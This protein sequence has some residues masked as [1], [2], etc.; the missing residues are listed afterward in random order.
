MKALI[1]VLALVIT[2]VVFSQDRTL[3][4]NSLNF[5]MGRTLYDGSSVSSGEEKG[6]NRFLALGSYDGFVHER[7]SI[8]V[9]GGYTVS[10]LKR[11][12]VYY[13]ENSWQEGDFYKRTI[14]ERRFVIGA[15]VNTYLVNTD[16]FQ[17]FASGGLAIGMRR[18]FLRYGKEIYSYDQRSLP[19]MLDLHL[20]VN[21]Y[22]SDH[23]G[24][25]ARIG[26]KLGLFRLG[27]TYRY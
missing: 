19:L 20:G 13:S 1:T 2:S 5:T 25:T 12:S 18:E 26:Y 27:L 16:Q 4:R 24:A 6:L 21:Y 17:V 22:F 10:S 14:R 9:F 8:G 11:D 3:L 23:L 7:L 15:R